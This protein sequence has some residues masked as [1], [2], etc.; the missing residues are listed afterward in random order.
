MSLL[1]A[2]VAGLVDQRSPDRGNCADRR[3]AVVRRDPDVPYPNPSFSLLADLH[4]TLRRGRAMAN[5][6]HHMSAPRVDLTHCDVEIHPDPVAGTVLVT[7]KLSTDAAIDVALHLISAVA[8]MKM[9]PAPAEA[10]SIRFPRS[11]PRPLT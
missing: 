6:H 5:N 2:A 7:V 10:G 9:S 8:Q 11:T 3:F 4:A 1:T